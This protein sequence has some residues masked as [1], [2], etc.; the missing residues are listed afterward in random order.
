MTKA[1]KKAVKDRKVCSRATVD[2]RIVNKVEGGILL[3]VE[4]VVRC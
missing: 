3:P 2:A 4:L 1:P